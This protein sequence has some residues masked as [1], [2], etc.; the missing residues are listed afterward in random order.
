MSVS[1]THLNERTKY[2]LRNLFIIYYLYYL[3]T[4]EVLNAIH[5]LSLGIPDLENGHLNTQ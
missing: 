1:D 2:A 5:F 4:S 3:P